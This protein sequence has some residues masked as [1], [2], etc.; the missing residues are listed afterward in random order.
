MPLIS[1]L[2]V[3]GIGFDRRTTGSTV[4]KDPAV[5]LWMARRIIFQKGQIIGNPGAKRN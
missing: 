2:L 4:N 3:S 5:F 1:L